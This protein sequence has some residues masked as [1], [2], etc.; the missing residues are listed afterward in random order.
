[1]YRSGRSWRSSRRL[2]DS[3]KVRRHRAF[4]LTLMVA[5][6]VA[7]QRESEPRGDTT[8]RV[9][10]GSPVASPTFA[11]DPVAW[12]RG[13]LTARPDTP[14]RSASNIK[15]G[16]HTIPTAGERQAMLLVPPDLD[17]DGRVPLMVMAHGAN[18]APKV[19][20]RVPR[21]AQRRGILIVSPASSGTTWDLTLGG[22][23][24]DVGQLDE[25]LAW[26]F[27]RFR[28]DPRRLAM[29]GFSDGASWALS[30]GLTNGDLFSHIIAFSPGYVGPTEP[31]GNPKI[32]ISHGR[33]DRVLPYDRAGRAI[34]EELRRN[35]YEVTLE[36][37]PGGH[38]LLHRN[39]VNGL[40]WFI[41]SWT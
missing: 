14:G 3:G 30:L 12:A 5:M 17:P 28:V 41:R 36:S 26:V 22:Y 9:A 40:E 29:A 35:D 18:G 34:S 25:A 33:N 7:C 24:P 16:L 23:G 8:G 4:G 39:M 2:S 20:A 21:L 1:M 10:D 6:L 38:E 27:D 13:R 15:T 32:Y 31:R 37:F 19:A 11:P